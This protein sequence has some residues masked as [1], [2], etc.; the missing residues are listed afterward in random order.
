MIVAAVC[1]FYFDHFLPVDESW[2]ETFALDSD[3]GRVMIAPR[4]A[5][6]PLFPEP[7]DQ[8]LS[9]AELRLIPLSRPGGE[10]RLRAR[11]RIID[12]MGVTVLQNDVELQ[13]G[14][15]PD[16]LEQAMIDRA[17]EAIDGVIAHCRVLTDAPFLDGVRR[18]HRP[19]DGNFYLL[20]PHTISWF[21]GVDLRDLPPL[22]V[23]G[24]VNA[25]AS[26]GAIRAPERGSVDFPRLL[27]SIRRGVASV[28][29]SLL[30]TAR[31]RLA[32]LFLR[33]GIIAAA[34]ALEVAFEQYL[35]RSGRSGDGEVQA[36]L[37][38][39][40][41]SFAERRYDRL[42][43]LISG[44]SLRADCPAEFRDVQR[45]YRARN[46]AA[47]EG[48]LTYNDNGLEVRVG[49]SRAV[50]LVRASEVAVE[51]LAQL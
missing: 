45:L 37:A 32:Q 19:D 9:T 34:T 10:I 36:I 49:Q 44:R 30:A 47:H 21:G 4:R 50:E 29:L 42:T 16:G 23:Y 39:R 11:D 38:D 8:T 35:E 17:V 6:D 1:Q 22:E 27:D 33:E 46:S 51:W 20:N 26:S 12:R 15:L 25:S 5:G 3:Q 48:A 13:D 31:E 14:R 40:T 43:Q 24:D 2:P 41:L 7:I 28:P 18:Q